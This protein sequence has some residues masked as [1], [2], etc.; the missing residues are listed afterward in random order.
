MFKNN[1]PS[2]SEIEKLL[3]DIEEKLLK[4]KYPDY[5]A[6]RTPQNLAD[7]MGCI[8]FAIV[9]LNNYEN[10][11]KNMS[12]EEILDLYKSSIIRK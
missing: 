6:W 7:S 11:L 3:Y 5:D 12:D 4:K 1:M 2:R 10:R 8:G 9:E